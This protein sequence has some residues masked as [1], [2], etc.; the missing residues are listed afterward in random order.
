MPPQTKNVDLDDRFVT[1]IYP[2]VGKSDPYPLK[3]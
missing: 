2:Y 1:P 3:L